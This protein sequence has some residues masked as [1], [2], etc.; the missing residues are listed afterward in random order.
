MKAVGWL[1]WYIKSLAI[2]LGHWL[3]LL[4]KPK[5]NNVAR[6]TATNHPEVPL[7]LYCTDQLHVWF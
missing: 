3:T 1:L 6:T 2:T 5:R 4:I 7:S